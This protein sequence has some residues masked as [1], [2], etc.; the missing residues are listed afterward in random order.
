MVR[1]YLYIRDDFLPSLSQVRDQ[2]PSILWTCQSSLIFRHLQIFFNIAATTCLQVL[3]WPLLLWALCVPATKAR[4]LNMWLIAA[5][6]SYVVWRPSK[7]TAIIPF[8]IEL[9]FSSFAFISSCKLSI[10][11]QVHEYLRNSHI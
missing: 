2:K 6:H 7:Q 1:L 5:S 8:F 11:S 10:L 4:S 3:F 9:Q